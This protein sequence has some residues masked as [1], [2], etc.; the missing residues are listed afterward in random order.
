MNKT[1][2]TKVS[3][4]V[5]IVATSLPLQALAAEE[6]SWWQQL[7]QWTGFEQVK[8]DSK[9]QQL[10][11][12]LQQLLLQTADNTVKQLT[13]E[14]GAAQ[15]EWPAGLGKLVSTLDKIGATEYSAQLK[16]SL[17]STIQQLAPQLTPILHQAIEQLPLQQITQDYLAG[18]GSATTL[19]K[20]FM[21]SDIN[22]Q[23]EPLLQQ[24]LA[25]SS[26]QNMYQQAIEQYNKVP[27][28]PEITQ[29][30]LPSIQQGLTEQLF[31]QLAQQEALIKQQAEQQS[32]LI[33]QLLQ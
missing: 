25:D 30:L 5:L 19:L 10:E 28:L 29:Q 11:A 27:F 7:K 21:S 6:L 14:Q 20:Q 8:T 13:T 26:L 33:Q 2:V 15:I 24:Y 18:N 1:I 4:S 31:Q 9:Q 3:A 16:Q 17:N 12:G 23:I 22:K 32:P